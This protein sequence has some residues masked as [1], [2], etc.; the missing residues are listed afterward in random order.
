MFAVVAVAA[1]SSCDNEGTDPVMEE[2]TTAAAVVASVVEASAFGDS[3]M[4]AWTE[5]DESDLPQVVLDYIA[6]NYSDETVH[7][8]W[9]DDNGG[10]VVLLDNRTAL[11]FDNTGAF[12]EAIENAGK[13]KGDDK[14]ELTNVDPADLPVAITDY[15]AANYADYTIDKAGTDADGNF[16][17]KLE[18][19]P[20]LIFDADGNFVEARERKGNGGKDGDRGGDRKKGKGKKGHAD[21]RW[22]A[23]D[24]ADL[25]AAIT[26]YIATNYPDATILKAGTDADGNYG[27]V[28]DSEVALI[29]DTD[30]VFVEEKGY[31]EHNGDCDGEGGDD[32]GEG[33][34]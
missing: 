33:E 22:T 5:I 9:V 12:V 8:A 16:H 6:D 23:I 2:D 11:R 29:F 21:D 30:G 26:D 32:D 15:I 3:D 13:R 10:Y 24:I 31:H 28:L 20:V 25:P 14:P 4:S 17:V 19:G 27:V 1:L 18:D 7:H 34:G